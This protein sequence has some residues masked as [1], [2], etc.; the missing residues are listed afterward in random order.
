MPPL[1]F[2]NP[3]LYSIGLQGLT[4]ITAGGSVGCNGVNG[5][6]GA[7]VPGGGVIPGAM[8]NA[9]RGWDPVTGLG[10]PDFGRL[11]ALALGR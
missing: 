6:T 1:G 7:V 8:W 3:W 11:M 9:T 2:L 4:D 5:Q 10:V